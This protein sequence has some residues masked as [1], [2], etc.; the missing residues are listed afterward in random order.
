MPVRFSG[1]W[2]ESEA[3]VPLFEHEL[4]TSDAYYFVCGDADAKDANVRK[5][6]DW[7]VETFAGV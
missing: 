3:L 2:F 4:V 7:V 5:L 6:R 1:K